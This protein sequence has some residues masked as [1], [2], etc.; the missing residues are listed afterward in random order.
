MSRQNAASAH[1]LHVE[2]LRGGIV[3]SGHRVSVAMVDARGQTLLAF[4]D[5]KRPVYMRSS[6]KPF[7]ALPFVEMGYID[8]YQIT[9]Q[10]L[11]LLCA[12]HS[13]TDLHVEVARALLENNGLS[14]SDLQCGTHIPPDRDTA[15]RLVRQGEA[16]SP[17]RHN[18]SGKHSGMLLYTKSAGEAADRYLQ[19]SSSVQQAIFKAFSEM[20]GV[21]EGEIEVGVD[22]CS[23]PNFAVPLPAAAYG[24]ARLMDPSDLGSQRA[25]ACERIVRAMSAF[26]EMVAGDGRFDTELM[27]A[28][29]GR[30]LAKGGAEGYQAVGVPSGRFLQGRAAGLTLKVHDGDN[31]RRAVDLITLVVLHVLE[32]VTDEE[33]AALPMSDERQLFNHMNVPMGEIRLAEESRRR[34]REAYER[35]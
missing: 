8:Q 24:Y 16:P 5:V 28:V 32:L 22:G 33:R 3:E 27:R 1:A 21:P 19:Q 2:L 31:A 30:L 25:Q 9:S 11:A 18:C 12:S 34:L 4:G 20:V 6:A 13:G 29:D 10:Q 17:L 23:A 7:Q 15:S 35:L 26:P 14:E